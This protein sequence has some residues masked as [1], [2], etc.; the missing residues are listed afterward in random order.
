M[1][2]RK[3]LKKMFGMMVGTSLLLKVSI[4]KFI[5]KDY[6]FISPLAKMERELKL[7]RLMKKRE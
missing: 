3:F 4:S 2:R 7:C 6:E 5:T 1:N